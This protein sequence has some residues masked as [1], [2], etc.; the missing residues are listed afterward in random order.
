MNKIYDLAVIFKRCS[1]YNK[2]FYK[3]EKVVE[4]YLDEENGYFVDN[5]GAVYYHIIEN[6]DSYGFGYADDITNYKKKYPYLTNMFIKKCIL[7]SIGKFDYELRYI[8]D[9]DLPVPLIQ[10]S[11]KKQKPIALFDSFILNYYAEMYKGF[12]DK[13]FEVDE[14]G[15]IIF[16]NRSEDVEVNNNNE[17][18]NEDVKLEGNIEEETKESVTI[19]IPKILEEIS[20]RVI[21]QDEP[22]KKILN[23]IWKHYSNYS[24]TKSRNIL[25]NGSTGVGKTETFRILSKLLNVPCV[26][27]SATEYTATGYIGKSVED[28]LISLITKANGDIEKAQ[29]GILI[30][31]EIDKL[32]E[33]GGGHSQ[34]NRRDVQE[35]LLKI[36]EDGE[37]T[38]NYNYQEYKF[39][40]SRLL[41]VGMGSW[42]RIDLTPKKHVGFESKTEKKTYKDITREDI[43]ANGLIPELVGRFSTL[44]QMNELQFDSFV[45]ILKS[46]NSVINLNKDF[47]FKQGVELIV[48]DSVIEAL[49]KE[50]ERNNYGARGLDE[51]V[52][53]TLAV[54]SFEIACNPQKYSKLIITEDTVKDN[55][56][57]ILEKREEHK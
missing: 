28:M 20:S 42:S 47:Y 25:I 44:V 7:H 48:V 23:A 1:T 56:K 53:R 11:S 10:M 31:D 2:T 22:I 34:V 27:T 35:S 18:L 37:F 50:A 14:N 5:D 40:T 26:I 43:V 15:S 12:F 33:S 41:V 36:L 9:R 32:S 39:D 30:I 21:D 16:K 55:K 8:E 29:N 46:K 52:E 49:A 38:L 51:I 45:K 19:D 57:Y 54:A 13:F 24:D 3:P 17:I 6:P 4:G